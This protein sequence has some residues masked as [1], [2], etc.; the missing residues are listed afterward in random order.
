M[1]HWKLKGLHFGAGVLHLG[2]SVA[3]F[4]LGS[5]TKSELQVRITYPTGPPGT[6]TYA[7]RTLPV[8]LDYMSAVFFLLASLQHAITVYRWPAYLKMIETEKRNSWRWMEYSISSTI[9]VLI[10]AILCGVQELSALIAIAGCN[11]AMI[12][13]GDLSGRFQRKEKGDDQRSFWSRIVNPSNR[14]L[15]FWYGTIIGLFPWICIFMQFGLNA[16]VSSPPAL[17]WAIT[18]SIIGLFFCFAG[19]EW[20]LIQDSK[21]LKRLSNSSIE[22]NAEMV[23]V[24]LSI[25]AKTALGWQS[26][27]AIAAIPH[28]P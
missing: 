16:S 8:I 24:I 12:L 14:E 22:F 28:N 5:L 7:L 20:A 18:I 21:Y 2:Q 6:T 27:F 26:H 1:S 17:V 9:M 23:Y 10:I 4:V 19:V 25:T 13:F 3:L 15:S 11:V